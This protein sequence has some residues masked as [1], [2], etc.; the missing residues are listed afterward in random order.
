MRPSAFRSAIKGRFQGKLTIA[1]AYV[2]AIIDDRYT[3]RPRS[4]KDGVQFDL[5][6]MRHL[7]IAGVDVVISS[8]AEQ[9]FDRAPNG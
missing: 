4:M 3:N 5:G 7:I 1:D 2:K 6:H 8:R 9:M